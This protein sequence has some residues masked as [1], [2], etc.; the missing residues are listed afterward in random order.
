MVSQSFGIAAAS[1]FNYIDKEIDL[2]PGYMVV[3]STNAQVTTVGQLQVA[4]ASPHP[5]YD[6]G[7]YANNIAVLRLNSN[8]EIRFTNEISDWLSNWT[9][10]SYVYNSLASTTPYKFN[11]PIV[12]TFAPTSD[13]AVCSEASAVYAQNEQDFICSTFNVT[14]DSATACAVP[15]GSVYGGTNSDSAILGA[16]FSHSAIYGD[17]GYCGSGPIYNY[18][19]V[20]RNYIPWINEQYGG[21]ISTYHTA[22]AISYIPASNVSYQMNNPTASINSNYQLVGYVTLDNDKLQRRDTISYISGFLLQDQVLLKSGVEAKPRIGVVAISQVN[23]NEEVTSTSIV[24]QTSTE[25]TSSTLT[26]TTTTTLSS[27]SAATTTA[28]LSTT[29]TLTTT[30]TSVLTLTSVQLS[31]ITVTATNIAPN[32]IGATN[33][34]VSPIIVSVTDISIMTVGNG[35][36]K[37]ITVTAY[38][39]Q[40]N[41]G[42]IIT[43]S[44]PD[45]TVTVSQ[46]ATV[47]EAA[48]SVT[49]TETTTLTP[50]VMAPTSTLTLTDIDFQTLVSTAT[51]ILTTTAI[52][53]IPT[54]SMIAPTSTS[55]SIP[56]VQP[57]ES[58]SNNKLDSTN[59]NNKKKPPASLIVAVVVISLLLLG[60]IIG[61]FL[62]RKRKQRELEKQEVLV[63]NAD[64]QLATKRRVD[65]WY[66]ERPWNRTIENKEDLPEYMSR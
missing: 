24:T 56:I 62:Y 2:S 53:D 16:I 44:M 29:T 45:I 25:I 39:S 23:S 31:V 8:E 4:K 51:S 18:Y 47:T 35:Q 5:H 37:T 3:T 36:T 7:T 50:L 41:S 10:Y 59:T 60:V 1:C 30:S 28:V 40:S 11:S 48:Q 52:P 34:I 14:P 63:Y 6:S 9:Q 66:L 55:N 64:M 20:L 19:T 15:F 21:Q 65:N 38:N 49:V 33:S 32:V 13:S 12:D 43:Q 27:T 57:T 22:N 17:E 42:Q 61:F 26:E 54:L 46:T 58:S